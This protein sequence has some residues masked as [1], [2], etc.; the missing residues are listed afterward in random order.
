MLSNIKTQF[1][2]FLRIKTVSDKNNLLLLNFQMYFHTAFIIV[3][4]EINYFLFI[5]NNVPGKIKHRGF[6]IMIFTQCV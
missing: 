1:R 4:M 5:Q 2:D 3:N 6:V